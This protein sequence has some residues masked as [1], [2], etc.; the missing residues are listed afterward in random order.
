MII[1]YTQDKTY[2]CKDG[3]EAKDILAYVY[4]D[5]LG[6]E[7]YNFV[8]KAPLG[9]T[10]RKN[11]GPLVRIVTKEQAEKIREKEKAIGMLI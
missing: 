5:K 3:N 10:Y 4:G 7:A 1:V 9:T 8:D 2:F 11:G 6:T